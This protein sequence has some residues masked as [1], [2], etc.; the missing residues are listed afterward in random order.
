[1]LTAIARHCVRH[2]SQVLAL[3]G[4]AAVLGLLLSPGLFERLTSEAGSVDGTESAR[5]SSLLRSADPR[6]PEVVAVLDGVR[7]D[8]PATRAATERLSAELTAVP[9]VEEVRTPWTLVPRGG[10]PHAEAVASDGRAVAVAVQVA[11]TE[12]GWAALDRVVPTLRDADAPRVLLGGETLMDEE[13]NDQAEADLARAELISL[14]VMLVLLLVL[15]GGVV[16]AG[17]P[18]VVAVTGIATTLGALSLVSMATD[19]SVYAVNIVTMLGLGL[20]VD[21]ALLVVSRFREERAGGLDVEAAVLATMATAGRTVAFSAATVSAALAGLTVFPDDFLRSMGLACIAV[22]LLDVVA[23]LTLLPA[24]LALAGGRVRPARAAAHDHGFFVR[25]SGVVRRRAV[26]VAL[27]ATTLLTLAAVPF[28]GARFTDPD[29]R[30]LP[31]SSETRQVAELAGTRFAA[32]DP[33]VV[34]VV[35][36]E[37]WSTADRTAYLRRL[38]Q[39]PDVASAGPVERADLTVVEVVVAGADD[40]GVTAGRVVD[41][42]RALP[43]PSEVQVTGDAARLADYRTAILDRL[44]WALLVIAL[45]TFALL[46]A[47]TGSVVVPLKALVMNTLSLGATFGALVWVFQG[48]HLGGLVGTE[49]LGSLSITTPVLVFAIA[50]GLSMDY[51]VFVL[52]RITETWRRTSDNDHAVAVGLQ[53]TGRT[54]TAAALLMVVVFGAFVAGGFSPVKQVGLGLVIAVVVDVTVVRMLLVPAA[55][56]LLGELNWWAPAPLR[57]LH[58]RIA[59]TDTVELPSAVPPRVAA[60]A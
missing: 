6:G 28:A 52:G 1:M 22:A 14:P 55:M 34:T 26:P 9:G 40:D 11:P 37:Q 33:E 23:A 59:L 36:T 3:W 30:S 13:M 27:V 5:A 54:V 44:P 50:F 45:T 8:D 35:A 24:L 43:A 56:R 57:R 7:A 25:L 10:A 4:V 21:Y 47:F 17:L 46:F 29:E 49:A 41:D 42:V 32:A 38:E 39:L 2:R 15:F 48:G 20:A 58:R 18:I 31:A 53:A 16:A 51:E 60:V 12:A 19:V